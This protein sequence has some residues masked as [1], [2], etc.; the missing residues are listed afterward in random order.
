MPDLNE[1]SGNVG[2]LALFAVVI[3]TFVGTVIGNILWVIRSLGFFKETRFA[4]FIYGG[5]RQQDILVK[6]SV[7]LA[8]EN[9]GLSETG[10]K[11]LRN[12]SKAIALGKVKIIDDG[13]EELIAILSKYTFEFSYDIRYG[14][15]T[16]SVS[17]YYINTMEAAHNFEDNL[18][19]AH[20]LYKRFVYN[21]SKYAHV[22]YVLVPKTGNPLLAKTFAALC[23]A[24]CIVC[25]PLNADSSRIQFADENSG[26]I[27]SI[28]FEGFSSLQS[29]A[30]KSPELL[31]GIVMDCNCSGGSS[32]IATSKAFNDMLQSQKIANIKPVTDVHILFRADV[33][34]T[35]TQIVQKF[36]S[37][38]LTLHRIMDVNEEL[39]SK[40]R[41]IHH[42]IDNNDG[43][44]YNEKVMQNVKMLA[45]SVKRSGLYIGN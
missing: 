13:F 32:L 9:I 40:L 28:N 45:E 44:M 4:K 29:K 43:E 11:N 27:P 23:G 26:I 8:L 33:V 2:Y 24:K 18:A 6:R 14:R 20:I 38:D 39:K 34:E 21:Y 15:V 41:K 16:P 37:N 7:S 17:K 42:L 19:L 22:D 25:K 35:Q 12:A 30:L 31:N 1:L 5:Q 10:I 36:K 3:V